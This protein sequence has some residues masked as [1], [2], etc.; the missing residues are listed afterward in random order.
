[1]EF[2]SA[3]ALYLSARYWG[4]LAGLI[5]PFSIVCVAWRTVGFLLLPGLCGHQAELIATDGEGLALDSAQG[6]ISPS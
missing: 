1:M 2:L 4:Y 6:Y 5:K 3:E